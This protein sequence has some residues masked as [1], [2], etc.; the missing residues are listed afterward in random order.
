MSRRWAGRGKEGYPAE[1][2]ARGYREAAMWEMAV[3]LRLRYCLDA[4]PHLYT[5]EI[6]RVQCWGLNSFVCSLSLSALILFPLPYTCCGLPNVYLLARPLH[7]GTSDSAAIWCPQLPG[8]L[9]HQLYSHTSHCLFSSFSFLC[10]T[11]NIRLHL[12]D[13]SFKKGGQPYRGLPQIPQS[14]PTTT[15]SSPSFFL[16]MCLS[17]WIDRHIHRGALACHKGS[18]TLTAGLQT[19]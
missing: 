1:R 5:W 8:Q 7:N 3:F 4:S 16:S 12:P 14:S 10:I 13:C 11:N 9:H 19:T 6:L 17:M 2:T 15:S 18:R